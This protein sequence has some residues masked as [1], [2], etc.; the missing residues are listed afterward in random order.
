MSLF[1]FIILYLIFKIQVWA[2]EF[3]D[4]QG[5]YGNKLNDSKNYYEV[6][7]NY[8]LS[9]N[10]TSSRISW[11]YDSINSGRN[12]VIKFSIRGKALCLYF[13]L[14]ADDYA[15]S[16]Y[17]VEKVES[18]KYEDVPCLYRIKNDRRRDY[19]KDLIDTVM[20][21]LPTE[22]GNES[23]E[24][25][26]IPF[27]T[28][29]ALLEKGL[30]KELKTKVTPNKEEAIQSISVEKADE[31]MSDEKAQASIQ[32]DTLHK[33]RIGTK[34]IINID[35]LSNNFNDGDEVTVEALIEKKLLPSKTGSVK[36]LARGTLDKK[37]IVC[38]NDY[39]LQAVKMIA[40]LGGKVKKVK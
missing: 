36:L 11:N 19:A 13:A 22:K 15:D 34:E 32:I 2:T 14:N 3:P 18:K 7:K 4:S 1:I 27:E 17:K 23:N 6:L 12:Q 10:K 30:I 20:N 26:R 16:K 39:S 21:N 38:L 28:T 24:E 9:Y 8:V 25:F 33:R 31:L 5:C 40:L 35:V 37:L 29:E